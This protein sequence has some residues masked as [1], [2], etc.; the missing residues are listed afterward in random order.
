M[1]SSYKRTAVA[2]FTFFAL[3][4]LAGCGG[5]GGNNSVDDG[6]G[7]NGTEEPTP[8]PEPV[9]KTFTVGLSS[10]QVVQISTGDELTIDTE[11][12]NGGDLEYTVP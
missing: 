10:V 6:T 5:G 4:V 8:T 12:I 9:V 1:R 11:S 3:A 2:L 7:D